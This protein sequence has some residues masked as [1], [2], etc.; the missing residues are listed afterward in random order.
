M[1]P[2]DAALATVQ[3]LARDLR[4]D[5][6]VLSKR[7]ADA[8]ARAPLSD[9]EF[10]KVRRDFEVML[11]D[12]T[13]FVVTAEAECERLEPLCPNEVRDLRVTL[14]KARTLLSEMRP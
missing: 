13:V 10:A 2:P 3:A 4:R 7:L 9:A 5:S 12:L 6:L 11:D 14:H 8:R 1:T